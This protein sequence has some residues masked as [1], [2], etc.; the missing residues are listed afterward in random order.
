MNATSIDYDV[1]SNSIRHNDSNLTKTSIVFIPQIEPDDDCEE[2][3]IRLSPLRTTQNKMESSETESFVFDE[4]PTYNPE[5]VE[6][7]PESVK[8]KEDKIESSSRSRLRN[9]SM[10]K[11]SMMDES[12]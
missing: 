6:V 3:S 9:Q 4:H 7:S 2:H 5:S 12:E 1:E 10:I 11:I 8:N